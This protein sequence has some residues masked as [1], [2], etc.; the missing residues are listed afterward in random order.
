MIDIILVFGYLLLTL[1]LGIWV[2]NKVNCSEDYKTG[3]KQYS[4][5]VIFATLSA[6]YIGGGFTF[7]LAEKTF[8]FGFVYIIA[9][10]G[11]SLKEILIAI[12][13]APRMQYF[14]NVFTVGDIME[15]AYGKRTKIITGIASVLVCSG[16][17]GAQ[18]SAC[19]S[20]IH[21]FLGPPPAIGAL[22][23]GSIVIIYASLGGLKSVVAVDILHFGLFAIILPLVLYFGIQEVGGITPLLTALPDPHTELFS[24]TDFK[25]FLVLF[26]SFFLGET[27]IPPYIQRLLIGKT[28][29]ATK[30][31]TLWSGIFSIFFF[32]IIGSIGM[33]TAILAPTLPAAS[34]LTYIIQTAMP[35][36]L[37]GL[38]IAAMLAVI[39]SSVDSFL[40]SIA[41]TF[42][43]DIL[44]PLGL[45]NKTK[46]HELLVYRVITLMIGSMAITI[47]LSLSSSIDILLYSYQFW[48]PF[49]LT[50]FVAAIFGIRSSEKTFLI[51]A[52]ASI[53]SVLIWKAFSPHLL[54]FFIDNA[55]INPK[56][57]VSFIDGALE[58]T[59]FGVIVNSLTFALCHWF[60]NGRE[61]Q[62]NKLII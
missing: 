6:S 8:L 13:I 52:I 55:L 56:L 25:T 18:V 60:F 45:L 61:L 44:K 11:F 21:T 5:W 10:W 51:S 32:L 26:L 20:I 19:G 58:G 40:N 29:Q 33:V 7:G 24:S 57:S 49:I 62:Q 1:I 23:A 36:G 48:T 17:V 9:I 14:Q 16:I 47:S 28:H 15:Q 42:S 46:N 34:A 53:I 30:Q 12:F 38:A 35:I 39:M 59:I 50:P 2:G 41:L 3:G 31:G 27:L 22:L 43:Q 37:K 4:A 54:V